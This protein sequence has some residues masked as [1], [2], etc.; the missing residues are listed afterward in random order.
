MKKKYTKPEFE[1]FSLAVTEDILSASP[2]DIDPDEGWK[3]A[4]DEYGA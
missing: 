3:D 4:D 2:E 1:A